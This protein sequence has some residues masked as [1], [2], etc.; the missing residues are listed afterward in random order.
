MNMNSNNRPTIGFLTANIHFGAA[1]VL[2]PGI[3]DAA[4]A[5]DIN[6]ICFPG[7]RLGMN[8]ATETSRNVIYKQVNKNQLDGLVIWTSALVGKATPQEISDF[9]QEYSDIPQVDMG[10]PF[11]NRQVVMIDGKQGRRALLLHL[12]EEHGYQKIAFIRGLESH[13]YGYRTYIETLQEKAIEIDERLISPPLG[14]TKGRE[15]MAVLLDERGL[16]P[17]RDF[18]AVVGASDLLAVGALR[19]MAERGIHVPTDTGLAGFNDVEEGRLVRPPLTSV[20]LPFYEQGQQA[21][22][23]VLALAAGN[24][25]SEGVHLR[26]RLLIRQSC[27]CRS[28]SEKL[29]SKPLTAVSKAQSSSTNPKANTRTVAS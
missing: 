27:G 21:L 9:H 19:L 3:L 8:V 28:W 18:Q 10:A 15:A 14:W 25:V 17:G 11:E 13:P 22:K 2:W 29:A 4:I 5:E 6:L 20:S 16:Q 23:T 26:S 24:D 12:I 1:R 7:G